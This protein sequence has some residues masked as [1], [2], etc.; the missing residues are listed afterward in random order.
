MPRSEC[1]SY[2]RELMSRFDILRLP[3]SLYYKIT[4]RVHTPESEVSALIQRHN[5]HEIIQYQKLRFVRSEG[6]SIET[7]LCTSR[8]VNH[9]DI[10]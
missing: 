5:E 6:N 9:F 8:I 3:E 10:G 7:D 1:N 4:A 2:P